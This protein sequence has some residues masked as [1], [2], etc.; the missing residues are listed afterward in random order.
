[1]A[2][3]TH[4]PLRGMTALVT[5]ASRGIGRA[6]ALA[7]AEAGAAVG[8]HFRSRPEAAA[9]VVKECAALGVASS[10]FE[11]DLTDVEAP[12]NLVRRV[13]EALGEPCILVHSAGVL[14][15]APLGMTSERDYRAAMDLHLRAGALLSQA[16][17]G[18]IRRARY[19]RIVFLGSQAGTLGAQGRAAY[20]ASKAGLH[21]L[22]KSLA[23]ELA[24]AGAT[25]NV[26][27][28]GFVET[29]MTAG[30]PE[31][32]RE[33]ILARIPAGRFASPAEI[34]ALAAFLCGPDAGYI[35]G[36]V[37][38]ADGGLSLGDG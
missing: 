8:I 22:A 21:G 16:M 19:G 9:E 7:L 1:M 5:G 13:A 27:S 17:L 34:A 24:G 37:L 36:Q 23:S 28:P 18:S 30:L 32:A 20:A 38:P 26:V 6:C 11:A 2:S 35:T 14:K 29:D 3:R 4:G 25:V 10:A 12:G 31:K 33:N 15:D